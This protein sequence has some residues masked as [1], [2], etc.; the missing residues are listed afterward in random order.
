[1]TPELELCVYCKMPVKLEDQF[2]EV[3]P[4]VQDSHEF[5]KPIYPQCAHVKCY[6]QMKALESD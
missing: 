3:E 4:A 1:M 6:E 5:G 2:V